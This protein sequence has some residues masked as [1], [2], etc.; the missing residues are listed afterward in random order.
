M[1]L[2]VMQSI[3]VTVTRLFL[4]L[5]VAQFA[6]L[7]VVWLLHLDPHSAWVTAPASVQ[8]VITPGFFI[9]TILTRRYGAVAC[10]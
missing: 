6:L 9:T 2:R 7:A 1:L 5:W 4:G 10:Y 8:F 3:L